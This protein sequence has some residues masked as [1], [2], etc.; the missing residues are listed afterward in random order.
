MKEKLHR[1]E[2]PV[3]PKA[4]KN[5]RTP[6]LVKYGDF[7]KVTLSPIKGSIDKDGPGGALRTRVTGGPNP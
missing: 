5:Y 4:R 3:V 1:N 7:R 2:Q 6:K